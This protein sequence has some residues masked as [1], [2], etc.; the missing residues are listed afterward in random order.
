M[1][2]SV[3]EKQKGSSVSKHTFEWVS[4]ASGN[5][6]MPSSVLVGGIIKRVVFVPGSPA[7]TA[8]YD[9]TLTD[10]DGV[11]VLAG[12]G[13]NLPASG[14]TQ[15]CPGIPFKDGTTT[16]TTQIIVESILTLNVTNAGNA[17]QGKVIVYVQ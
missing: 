7:P 2:W 16:S 5:V 9:V 8:L 15:V 13:A 4:D 12:Q 3:R 10:S 17:T 11:D 1:V 6:T 14:V